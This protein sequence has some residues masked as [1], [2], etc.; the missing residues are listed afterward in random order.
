MAPR[1][2]P[3]DR[4]KPEEPP[5]ATPLVDGLQCVGVRSQVELAQGPD[6]VGRPAA[7]GAI[8]IEDPLDAKDCLSRDRILAGDCGLP[9]LPAAVTLMPSTA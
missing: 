8:E 2:Y 6:L 7:P 9:S 3:A 5:T 4:V 1:S